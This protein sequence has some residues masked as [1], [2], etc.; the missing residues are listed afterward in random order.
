MMLGF[1]YGFS[2]LHGPLLDGLS[3]GLALVAA[4]VV[5]QAVVLMARSLT[6]DAPRAAWR[7]PTAA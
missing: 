2:L 4:A 1:A 7:V 6:P 3:R 5:A